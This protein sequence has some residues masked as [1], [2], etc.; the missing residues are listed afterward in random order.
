MFLN[1][2]EFSLS[3][4]AQS[5]GIRSTRRM[6]SMMVGSTL[7]FGASAG[8]EVVAEPVIVTGA[9]TIAAGAANAAAATDGDPIV[10]EG[11]RNR[12]NTLN[13]RLPDVRDAPQ[14]IS[15]I[16]RQVME[17]QA[18]S[19]LRDVLRN[20]SGISMAAGEGG[21]GPAGDN[22]TLRGFGARNDIFIDGI[23][24]FA[25]YTRDTFNIEQVEVVKGPSS[26]QTGR[27]ST[28][29]YINMFTKQPTLDTFVG[30]TA[31]VGTSD[32]LR[33]TADVNI[34][35]TDL[36]VGAGTAMRFNVMIHDADTP[37]RDFVGTNRLGFA[38]S[39][40]VGLGTTTRAILSYV[41]MKQNNVPDYGI[42]FLGNDPAPVDYDNYY[43]LLERDREKLNSH[44]LT[45][46]IEHDLSDFVRI[47]NTTRFGHARR[48]SITSSPRF[49][50]GS[51]TSVLPQTQSRDTA[52]GIL[53]NQSN[54]FAKF[55]TGGIRHDL[56]AGFEVSRE[57]SRNQLRAISNGTPTDLFDPDPERPWG[58]T[59]VDRPGEVVRARAD[60]VAAY[61]FDTV[62]FSEKLLASGG[63]R[64]EH[65][66]TRF[67]PAPSQVTSAIGD[68]RRTDNSVTWRAGLTYK[69]VRR[70]SL[71][72]GAG[73]SVNPSI[74][75]MTQTT[76]SLAVG[77]LKPE[78]SRTVEVGA[79]WDGFKGKLLLT[80]ALF[81]TDKMN[82]RTIG[83]AGDPATV[84]EGKQRVDGAELGAIGRITRNWQVIAAYTYLDSEVRSSNEDSEIGNR[85][86][87]VPTHSGS[88]W[89]TV[90][91]GA[92]EVGGGVRYVGTRY[93]NV[94]NVRRI[95]DYW[96][97]D[98][99]LAY[100]INK[101]MTVRLNA[102]NLTDERFI[103]QVGGGHFISGQSR[104][105]LAT[106]AFRS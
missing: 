52:D 4:R 78:K 76:P 31:S 46:A 32:F 39:I 64:F 33:G 68:I 42:P 54:L 85:L 5:A 101:Q 30:G 53:L 9:E 66:R 24:D 49:E 28:G 11:Q 47:S 92:F 61:L 34:G 63:L 71:Y 38:P 65:Y 20:V 23:R 51:T 26:A 12:I 59:I 96:V 67:E 50:A 105:L 90:K 3:L 102:F 69:P 55:A 17:Q 87:N 99:T 10:V 13:T 1:S 72:A 91:I 22:L 106:L 80:A 89:S 56:V 40:A 43:G 100:D 60:S 75:N 58:G 84:L 48:D 37:G 82:A 14:S 103:D 94:N 27:G 25:S 95:E 57:K 86:P 79:K 7:L 45:F 15:I 29:G 35:G 97:G 70:L 81:R 62:H 18:A 93:T 88:L 19:T 41:Y 8:A 104:S 36:G 77:A 98:A 21:G 6:A 73:T 16:P 44:L 83:L 74:E 2:K